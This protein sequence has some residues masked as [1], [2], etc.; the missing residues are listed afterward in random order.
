MRPG[1]A[2]PSQPPAFNQ[3]C[4]SSRRVDRIDS[5]MISMSD[6]I[7]SRQLSVDAAAVTASTLAISD[8][9]KKVKEEGALRED[10]LS[11]IQVI[12]ISPRYFVRDPS[13]PRTS[14]RGLDSKGTPLES[15]HASLPSA[16]ATTESA[17]CGAPTASEGNS[18]LF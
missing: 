18:F 10:V 9:S 1:C 16:K 7:C 15:L 8:C 14:G 4:P 3:A 2:A 5:A 12:K 17:N 13:L 11:E 6:A